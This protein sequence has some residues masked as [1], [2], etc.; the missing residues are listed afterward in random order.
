MADILN[1]LD[2]AN[3]NVPASA[4]SLTATVTREVYVMPKD[5]PPARRLDLLVQCDG[6]VVAVIE[7]KVVRPEDAD[8]DKDKYYWQW[9][10]SQNPDAALFYSRWTGPKR[11]MTSLSCLR[12]RGYASI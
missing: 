12:G 4:L 1:V 3:A 10:Q 8:L 7:V 2:V 5:G 9:A 6:T 11:F